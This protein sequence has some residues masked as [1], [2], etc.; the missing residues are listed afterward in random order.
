M[1]NVPAMRTLL[2]A[3]TTIVTSTMVSWWFFREVPDAWTF[4]G[5]TEH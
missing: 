5:V 3:S 1:I 4:T 2:L